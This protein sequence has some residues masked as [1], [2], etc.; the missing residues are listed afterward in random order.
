M[1]AYKHPIAHHWIEQTLVPFLLFAFA[2]ALPYPADISEEV[3]RSIDFAL[4]KPDHPSDGDDMI[5]ERI[6]MAF[7]HRHKALAPDLARVVDNLEPC[8]KYLIRRALLKGPFE[9]LERTDVGSGA[10]IEHEGQRLSNLVVEGGEAGDGTLRP[11]LRPPLAAPKI[12]LT[13]DDLDPRL[14]H[15]Q[16]GHFAAENLSG[17]LTAEENSYYRQQNRNY[18]QA[19][20]QRQQ[21]SP[22]TSAAPAQ[23][24][25]PSYALPGRGY[26]HTTSVPQ[27]QQQKQ[28]TQP[29]ATPS[30][31]FAHE[32]HIWPQFQPAQTPPAQHD[33]SIQTPRF[34]PTLPQGQPM[35]PSMRAN[36]QPPRL[37]QF[38]VQPSQYQLPQQQTIQHEALQQQQALLK[39][40][41]RQISQ[42][43]HALVQIPKQSDLQPQQ[44]PPPTITSNS[45]SSNDF[46]HLRGNDWSN[47]AQ[48]RA[49]EIAAKTTAQERDSMAH[50]IIQRQQSIAQQPP[51]LASTASMYIPTYY[52]PKPFPRSHATMG[53]SND[54]TDRVHSNTPSYANASPYANAPASLPTGTNKSY[55]YTATRVTAAKPGTSGWGM[56]APDSGTPLPTLAEVRSRYHP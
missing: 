43:S 29:Q 48:Q 47:A 14:V 50:S 9:L 46:A 17:Q 32:R 44:T 45:I 6:F 35:L 38:Q 37:P 20:L 12:L 4:V 7:M 23:M 30:R 21:R 39:S 24:T 55:N 11:P 31:P 15:A 2:S 42:N 19:Q 16:P 41:G 51:D 56:A 1:T 53:L 8:A 25:E 10:W 5:F 34:F 52:V 49:R 54:R 33:N 27:V 22:Y 28:A 26:S 40:E 3:Q 18:E 36:A 13:E